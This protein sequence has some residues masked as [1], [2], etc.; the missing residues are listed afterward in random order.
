VERASRRPSQR[1]HDGHGDGSGAIA[2]PIAQ[3]RQR[4]PDDDGDP[5]QARRIAKCSASAASAWLL[6][7]PRRAMQRKRA[8]EVHG[9]IDQQHDEGMAEIVGGG[10]P[11]RRWLQDATRM[12][13]EST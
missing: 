10:A 9:D 13:P 12:P 4:E 5:S 6:V 8:P 3:S 11:S 1:D 7:S 2:P